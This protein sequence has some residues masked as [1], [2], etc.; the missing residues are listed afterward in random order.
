[1]RVDEVVAADVCFAVDLRCCMCEPIN[2]LPPRIR[3]G[4]LHHLD[5]DPSNND[6]DN[7]VWLCLEHH[8]DA[9]K[10]G[11]ASR[12]LS[13]HTIRKYRALLQ[14]RIATQRRVRDAVERRA[15][16]VFHESLDALVVLDVQKVRGRSDGEWESEQRAVAEISSYPET[17]GFEA[18]R[19]IL[20]Y[21]AHLASDTR[22]DMPQLVAQ[23]IRRC[24]IEMLQLHY[25]YGRRGKR[26]TR[27]DLILLEL[28]IEIGRDMAYDGALYLHNLRIVDEGCE[29]LWRLL[30]YSKIHRLKSL[31]TAVLDG[32]ETV[33]DGATR[34]ENAAA[35]SL[36]ETAR[37]YGDAGGTRA[38]EY[39]RE[40]ALQL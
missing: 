3:N 21:L 38:P 40:L 8:E 36:V 25:L 1:M 35:V 6:P 29:I 11:R 15:R 19:A 2:G 28:G 18:R 26:T 27:E 33:L 16:S 32:F 12:R 5:E 22:H 4:Q 24:T 20:D 17:I 37:R 31:R 7:L 23:M 10:V 39:P 34:S 30:S 14:S 13:P 9:G